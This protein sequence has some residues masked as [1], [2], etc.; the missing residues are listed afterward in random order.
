MPISPY[1]GYTAGSN[2]IRANQPV[3][4][5]NISALRAL[6]KTKIG[7]A[8]TKGYHTAGDGGAGEYWYDSSDTTSADNGGTIITASDGGR[9]KL[10]VVGNVTVKQF[11]AVGDG[12]TDDTISVQGAINTVKRGTL[13]FPP[14]YYKITSTLNVGTT[15]SGWAL[16]LIGSQALAGLASLTYTSVLYFPTLAQNQPMIRLGPTGKSD[17]LAVFGICFIGSGT[18]V[19]GTSGIFL[20]N[21]TETSITT[22]SPGTQARISGCKFENLCDG[23]SGFSFLSVIEHNEFRSIQN[24]VRVFPFTNDL[25]IDNNHFVGVSGTGIKFSD[26]GNTNLGVQTGNCLVTRNMFEGEPATAHSDIY[27]DNGIWLIISDN[28]FG[29]GS[30][31][32]CIYINSIKRYNV[33]RISVS[34]N[35]FQGGSIA[36]VYYNNAQIFGSPNEGN[37]QFNGNIGTSIQLVTFENISNV[38]SLRSQFNNIITTSLSSGGVRISDV[39]LPLRTANKNLI[40]NGNFASNSGADYSQSFSGTLSGGTV[41]TGWTLGVQDGNTGFYDVDGPNTGFAYNSASSSYKF[42]IRGQSGGGNIYAYQDVPVEKNMVYT[43]VALV[44]SG[45][46]YFGLEI[47][48][49]S[50]NVMAKSATTQVSSSGLY[51]C[52]ASC[53]SLNNSVIRIR[54]VNYAGETNQKFFHF[55][56]LYEG[57]F[58][59]GDIGYN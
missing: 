26:F 7:Y 36:N 51:M 14:G 13:Y 3:V 9:W 10:N 37:I 6:D 41:P 47:T 50:G 35:K 2:W 1:D 54:I 15:G 19:Q 38:L 59:C 55:V 39:A 12:V 53:D 58:S 31:K 46:A 18:N 4:V 57:L 32:Y 43:A 49:T 5:T 30:Q 44:Y 52:S 29:S 16:H 23:I 42:C 27:I 28:V 33:N 25:R 21:D 48:D 22:N 20:G 56:A 17:N 45:A 40:S 34:D 11:G 24:G 8:I